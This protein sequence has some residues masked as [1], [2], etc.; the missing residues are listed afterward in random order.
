MPTA[1][2]KSVS[3]G[4][5]KPGGPS[6]GAYNPLPTSASAPTAFARAAAV[7]GHNDPQQSIPQVRETQAQPRDTAGAYSVPRPS[8]TAPSSGRPGSGGVE[9]QG[10][11]QGPSRIGTY[12]EPMAVAPR[13]P[14]VQTDHT[15]RQ[16]YAG[17]EPAMAPMAGPSVGVTAESE[18]RPGRGP[19]QQ[20]HDGPAPRSGNFPGAFSGGGDDQGSAAEE[21]LRT[22]D[23]VRALVRRNGATPAD[24]ET[25]GRFRAIGVN[26]PGADRGEG[27]E[28][29]EGNTAW[30]RG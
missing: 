9:R 10:G 7:A 26:P 19:L 8:Y 2:K 30:G 25:P 4:Y 27:Y 22:R 29:H 17:R 18:T 28:S 20:G 23:A 3:T 24:T 16:P 14:G 11:R 13:G 12:A 6:F 5:G 15:G 1:D 21:G